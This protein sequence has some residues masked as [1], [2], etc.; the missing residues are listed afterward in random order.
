MS[1]RCWTGMGPFRRPWPVNLSQTGP[2]RSTGCWWTLGTG[3]HWRSA[4]QVTASPGRCG[5]GC[6]CGTGSARSRVADTTPWT[7]TPTTSS[8]G[9]RAAPPGSAT[10]DN[11]APN[12]TN[13]ATP[14]DGN[15]H[16]PAKTNHPAGPHPQAAI[17]KA[18]TRT[19][20]HH[21]GL[22]SKIAAVRRGKDRLEA[23][24]T[25][26][27]S[28]CPPGKKHWN[29]YFTPRPPDTASTSRSRQ[30][31]VPRLWQGP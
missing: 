19:G 8:P 24:P 14:P 5:P 30:S 9:P 29:G 10:W 31:V 27:T 3:R 25:S 15:Q 21:Y 6:G 2:D 23:T 20:N 26:S 16:P 12:T 13:S 11:P 4:G 18:N 17:T 22:P 7:T 28:G 1:R